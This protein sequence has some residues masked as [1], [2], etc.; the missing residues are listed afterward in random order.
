LS[1]SPT[2]ITRRGPTTRLLL[3]ALIDVADL[4]PGDR[5]LEVGCGTGK[6]TVPLARLGFAI[7]AVELGADWLRSRD[8]T[9]PGSSA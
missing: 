1:R 4:R 2:T 6:A 3:E 9:S 8:A 5:L 7:T